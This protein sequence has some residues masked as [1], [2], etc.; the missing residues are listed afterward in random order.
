MVNFRGIQLKFLSFGIQ[1]L[2]D[3]PF[4]CHFGVGDMR[5]LRDSNT[6]FYTGV[7]KENVSWKTQKILGFLQSINYFL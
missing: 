5:T 2:P 4:F 1:I 3:K 6:R 7:Y